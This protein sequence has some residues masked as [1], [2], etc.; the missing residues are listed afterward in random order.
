MVGIN[1]DFTTN[2]LASIKFFLD[3]ITPGIHAR[4]AFKKF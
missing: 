4:L 3:A 1:N 2:S